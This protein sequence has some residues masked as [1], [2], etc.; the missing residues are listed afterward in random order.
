MKWQ[1]IETAPVNKWVLVHW[2]QEA[3]DADPNWYWDDDENCPRFA[4]AYVDDDGYWWEP[5]KQDIIPPQMWCKI[6]P[7]K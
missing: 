3:I 1:P 5:M 7:P 2:T 4:V 6:V